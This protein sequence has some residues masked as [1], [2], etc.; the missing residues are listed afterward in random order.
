LHEV[1]HAVKRHRSPLYDSLTQAEEAVQEREADDLAFEWFNVH[2]AALGNPYLL[3]LTRK[4][5]DEAQG[6]SRLAMD[7]LYRGA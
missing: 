2:I 3:P 1:V 6:R 7:R 5:I 4:D